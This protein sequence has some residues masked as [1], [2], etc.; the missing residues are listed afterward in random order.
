MTHDELAMKI[1][2]AM[3]DDCCARMLKESGSAIATP[4]YDAKEWTAIGSVAVS[5]AMEE[6]AKLCEEDAD[7][8]EAAMRDNPHDYVG[9]AQLNQRRAQSLQDAMDIRKLGRKG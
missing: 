3:Y 7:R 2:R 6:A 1:G 5:L 9:H 4:Y 8:L